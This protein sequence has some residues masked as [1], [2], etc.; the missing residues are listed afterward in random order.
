MSAKQTAKAFDVFH[1][2]F[3]CQ[4][5][6]HDR[7]FNDRAEALDDSFL[8]AFKNNY[9]TFFS[10]LKELNPFLSGLSNNQINEYGYQLRLPL[11]ETMKLRIA[12]MH[13]LFDKDFSALVECFAINQV[14]SRALNSQELLTTPALVIEKY[15]ALLRILFSHP[16]KISENEYCF[17]AANRIFEWCFSGDTA[18]LYQSFF[19]NE[20]FHPF[21]RFLNTIIWYYLI[22]DGW[23]HWHAGC[24]TDLQ[25]EASAGKEVVYIAGGSDLIPLLKN[26][27]YSIRVI[28]PFLPSQTSY[29]SEGWHFLVQGDIGDE[30]IFNHE[31]QHITLRRSLQQ[32]NGRF[33]VKLSTG[34]VEEL[35]HTTTIWDIID[36]NEKR[37]GNIIIERRL[38]ANND[39]IPQQDK[40]LVMSY[41]EATY[42]ALPETLNGWGIDITQF[43]KTFK[44]FIKQLRTPITRIE[45]Y[46]LRIS[47][48]LNHANLKFINFGSDPS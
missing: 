34:S 17:A 38:A 16:N 4:D 9:E 6:Y 26:R 30:I 20:A 21:A 18:Q 3:D 47:S 35:P 29:Y 13:Q 5:V 41:D 31:F 36:K 33:Y 37:L 25:Q 15:K 19:T 39:F 42:I 1:K 11:D 7:D 48:L 23:K 40:T 28:D 44:L 8:L 12:L 14:T 2:W 22:G 43:D 24:L 46:N 27:I 45:L 32:E 10:E